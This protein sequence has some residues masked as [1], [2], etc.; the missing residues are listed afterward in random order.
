MKRL[1]YLLG[2]V[3]LIV[4]VAG[5]VAL[6]ALFHNEHDLEVESQAFVDSAIPAI[7]GNWSEK[8][9]LDRS[10]TELQRSSKPDEFDALFERLSKFGP[11]VEYQGAKGV[12]T[13]SYF[14]G[15]GGTVSASY[16]AKARFQNADAVFQIVLMQRDGRWLIHNFHVDAVPGSQTRQ[17]SL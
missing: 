15:S 11:L 5:T 3:T 7:T 2:A 9:L 1:L 6:P 12:V 10:T 17:R 8:E 13:M 4:I 16:D 14:S